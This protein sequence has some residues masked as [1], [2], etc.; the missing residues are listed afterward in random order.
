MWWR[1]WRWLTFAKQVEIIGAGFLNFRLA[2]SRL[3]QTLAAAARGE[4]FVF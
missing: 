2:K 3:E 1:G 4:A